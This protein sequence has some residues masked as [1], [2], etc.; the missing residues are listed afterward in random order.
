MHGAHRVGG[1]AATGGVVSDT[2]FVGCAVDAEEL[3]AGDVAVEPL[4]VAAEFG[5][6]ACCSSR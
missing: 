1:E 6:Y 5:E 3:V 4:D 2:I